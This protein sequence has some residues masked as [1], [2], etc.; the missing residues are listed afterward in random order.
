VGCDLHCYVEYR[1]KRPRSAYDREWRDF[2]G[3]VNPGRNYA[4]FAA[5]A[6]VRGPQSRG[7]VEPRGIPDDMAWAARGD[8]WL[9]IDDRYAGSSG[10]EDGPTDDVELLVRAC[11]AHPGE[12][13]PRRAL[14]DELQTRYG[15]DAVAPE[16]L[17]R[18]RY[19]GG[20]D[21]ARYAE[22]GKKVE[23]RDGRPTAVEH[24]DWHTPTWLAPD[25]WERALKA[26]RMTPPDDP[27]YFA[28]LGAMR[29]L[30][31]AGYKVRVV[32]WFDN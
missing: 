27:K 2:G 14:C 7:G 1:S 11:L 19:V 21:A 5:L 32:C 22:Y 18:V 16:F 31:A 26:A 17:G 15:P 9:Y 28:V 13:T 23:L 4:A 25:E 20:K 3:R 24:P 10:G 29:A 30:E 12:E 6:G 8:W